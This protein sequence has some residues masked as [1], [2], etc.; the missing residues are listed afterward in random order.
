MQLSR[1]QFPDLYASADGF[2]AILGVKPTPTLYLSNGN[3]PLN[4]FAAQSGW[5]N[6]WTVRRV[7]RLHQVGLFG[8]V[9]QAHRAQ[10]LT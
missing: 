7:W 6:N 4:A 8:T 1:T 9:D 2:A 10:E 3:G 5:A